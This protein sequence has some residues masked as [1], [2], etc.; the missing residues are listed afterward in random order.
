M[1]FVNCSGVFR[2]SE[3]WFGGGARAMGKEHLDGFGGNAG[4]V[5]RCGRAAGKKRGESRKA[6]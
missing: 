3:T 6:G 2:R 1:F 5:V 4:V